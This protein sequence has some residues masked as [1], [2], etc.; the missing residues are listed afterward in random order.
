M[1]FE[2][3]S[4]EVYSSFIQE[5]AASL[6]VLLMNATRERREEIS[7]AVTEAA[8]KYAD[9]TGSVKLTNETMCVVGTK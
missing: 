2:F 7:K 3:E 1:T 8:G 5:T 6:Q 9:N 4:A